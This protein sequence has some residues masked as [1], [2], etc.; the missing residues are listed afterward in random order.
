MD[1]RVEIMRHCRMIL[2]PSPVRDIQARS[3]TSYGK[4]TNKAE[5]RCRFGMITG[6]KVSGFIGE[7]VYNTKHCEFN[8]NRIQSIHVLTSSRIRKN[9]L[10]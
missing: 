6:G 5:K 9:P 1:N 8:S 2:A 3:K 10:E 7:I 4:S